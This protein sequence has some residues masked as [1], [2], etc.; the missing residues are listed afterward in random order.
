MP[1]RFNAW[2]GADLLIKS[3]EN[4]WY[5]FSLMSTYS[6]SRKG[7]EYLFLLGSRFCNKNSTN[8]LKG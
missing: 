6:V 1:S 2:V 5:L 3:K 4:R 7:N 8:Q